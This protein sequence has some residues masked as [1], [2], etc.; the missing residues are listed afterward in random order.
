MRRDDVI[1][2]LYRLDAAGVECRL[3]GGLIGS[4]D[5]ACVPAAA[6]LAHARG[7]DADALRSRIQDP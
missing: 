3:G 4:R 7:R 2:V 1:S 6:R 5:V